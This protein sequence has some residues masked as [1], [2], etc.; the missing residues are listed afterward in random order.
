MCDNN[1]NATDVG[2]TRHRRGTEEK[3]IIRTWVKYVT[4]P[5]DSPTP[6]GCIHLAAVVVYIRRG[7]GEYTVVRWSVWRHVVLGCPVIGNR[8]Q[9]NPR[10]GAHR[11]CKIKRGINGNTSDYKPIR[12]NFQL[13]RAIISNDIQTNHHKDISSSRCLH[14]LTAY[15][16]NIR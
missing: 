14:F 15:K 13:I 12:L 9:H 1:L 11:T 5:I 16:N 10:R 6:K 7:W 2:D 8:K 4:L 3:K